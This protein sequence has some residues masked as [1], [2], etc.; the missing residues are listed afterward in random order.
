MWA[1]G[2]KVFDDDWNVVLDQGDVKKATMEY[3][4]FF[5]G[6]TEHMPTGIA[7]ASWGPGLR[8]FRSGQPLPCPPAPGAPST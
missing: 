2:S 6:L 4:D 7:Q 1:Q 3:L 8:G 5:V